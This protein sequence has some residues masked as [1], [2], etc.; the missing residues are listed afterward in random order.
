MHKYLRAVGFSDI[1][2]KEQLKPYIRET[3]M[4]PDETEVAEEDGEDVLV[5]I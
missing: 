1:K 4:S 3:V 5:Q 2:L